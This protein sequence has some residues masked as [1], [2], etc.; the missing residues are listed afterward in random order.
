MALVRLIQKNSFMFIIYS[1][2]YYGF[3][4]P[5]L[6]TDARSAP[7]GPDLSLAMYITTYMIWLILGSVWAH[8]QSEFKFRGYLF[9]QQIPVK[10]RDIVLSKFVLIFLSVVLFSAAHLLLFSFLLKS[11]E[12]IVLSF[13]HLLIIAGLCLILCGLAYAGIFRF[14]F[15]AFGKYLVISW[16][17][18]LV[19]PIALTIFL[20]PKIGITRASIIRFT[21]SVPMVLYLPACLLIYVLLFRLSVRLKNRYSLKGDRYA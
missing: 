2:L 10:N 6:I 15:Y 4:F 20:F 11:R 7:G 13:H 3:L 14:G 5:L 16:I 21:S 1:G 19:I 9:L 18:I 12:H 8:E 17:L